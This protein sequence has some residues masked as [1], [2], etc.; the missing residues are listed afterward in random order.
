MNLQRL[1]SLL[2]LCFL[3][4]Q[5]TKAQKYSGTYTAA[6]MAGNPVTLVLQ[7]DAQGQVTGSFSAGGL[8]FR[9]QGSVEDEGLFGTAV[10]DAGSMYLEAYEEDGEIELILAELG[11]NNEPNF[12]AASEI[13]LHR[14]GSAS[15]MPVQRL[16]GSLASLQRIPTRFPPIFDRPPVADAL[17][18]KL[19]RG[20]LTVV[21]SVSNSGFELSMTGSASLVFLAAIPNSATPLGATFFHCSC[22]HEHLHVVTP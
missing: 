18:D 2:A 13:I 9:V 17:I 21:E 12:D 15:N 14:E 20:S 11:P 5:P 19:A 10:G 22:C 16:S 6:D 4:A 1:L 3:V 8:T 7:R